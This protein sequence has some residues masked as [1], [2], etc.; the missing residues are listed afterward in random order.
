MVI[1]YTNLNLHYSGR[2][3]SDGYEALFTRL[4]HEII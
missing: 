2:Y 1:E 3:K 4:K